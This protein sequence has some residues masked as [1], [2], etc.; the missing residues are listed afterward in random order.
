MAIFGITLAADYFMRR[1]GWISQFTRFD[2]DINIGN[3]IPDTDGKPFRVENYPVL[4][5]FI[6]QRLEVPGILAIDIADG[7]PRVAGLELICANAVHTEVANFL[8]V[9]TEKINAPISSEVHLQ[10]SGVFK[11]GED[12]RNVTYLSLFAQN[13]ANARAYTPLLVRNS[14]PTF[15]LKHLGELFSGNQITPIYTNARTLLNSQF[16]NMITSLVCPVLHIDWE[17]DTSAINNLGALPTGGIN[18]FGAMPMF[19]GITPGVSYAMP[20]YGGGLRG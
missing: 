10:F 12:T 9:A 20:I 17:T 2:A 5:E 6:Q 14:D 1:Q 11:N 18:Q 3:L 8:G 7:S 19:G 4:H 15:T 13:P 16:L